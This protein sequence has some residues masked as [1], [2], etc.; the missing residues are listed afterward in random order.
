MGPMQSKW[1]LIDDDPPLLFQIILDYKISEW[2]TD[3]ESNYLSLIPH[4]S[5]DDL[6]S[7]QQSIKILQIFWEDK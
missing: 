6:L 4:L 1:R 2:Y 5:N 7:Y 3:F